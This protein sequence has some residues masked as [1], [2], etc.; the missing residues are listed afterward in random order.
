MLGP[1]V[2]EGFHH[3]V[4]GGA[5]DAKAALKLAAGEGLG[6]DVVHRLRL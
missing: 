4:K 1:A 6:S 5:L 3:L 2:V